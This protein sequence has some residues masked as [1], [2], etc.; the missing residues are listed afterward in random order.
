MEI[1]GPIVRVI[2]DGKPEDDDAVIIIVE[3]HP[4]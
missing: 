4:L 2:P 1:G 3:S